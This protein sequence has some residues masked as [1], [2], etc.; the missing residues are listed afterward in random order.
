M[1]GKKG[2]GSGR[3][4]IPALAVVC[5]VAA[6]ASAGLALAASAG[7]APSSGIGSLAP[8]LVWELLIG[9]TV[10]AS[11]LGA[12]TLSV[13]SA[14]RTVRRASKPFAIDTSRRIRSIDWVR[15]AVSASTPV[16]TKL[17]LYSGWKNC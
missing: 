10:V 16:W 5:L 13:L 8:D 11:F 14:L 1:A 7:F 12:I 4:L 17:S 6:T 9:G 2:Q 3:N 15:R